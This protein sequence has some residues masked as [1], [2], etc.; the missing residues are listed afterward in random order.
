MSSNSSTD[1]RHRGIFCSED[2][3]IKALIREQ[4]G[5]EVELCFYVGGRGKV[6]AYK[7]CEFSIRGKNKGIYFGKIEKDGLRL[8]IEGSFIVGRFA[9]KGVLEIHEREAIDWLNGKD[10]KSDYKGYCILRWGEYF[11][12]CGKG[13]GKVIKNYVPKDRRLR[14]SSEEIGD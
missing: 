5:A 9:K 8:S 10:L 14:A 6:Y 2:H 13:N 3:K 11:L 1:E 7:E 12:G 4:F